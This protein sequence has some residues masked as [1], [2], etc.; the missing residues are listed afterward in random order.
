MKIYLL[1]LGAGILVGIIYSLLN[2][3]SPAPPIVAL[4]GL[5]GILV[6]EQVIPVGRQLLSGTAFSSACSKAHAISH[7]F[8]QL[9]GRQVAAQDESEKEKRS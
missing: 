6:G 5:F 9:P 7:I 1:S 8:G 3:R 2:V 4:V